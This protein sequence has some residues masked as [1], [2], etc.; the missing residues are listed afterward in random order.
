MPIY[1]GGFFLGRSDCHFVFSSA[2]IWWYSNL[3]M[4]LEPKGYRVTGLESL[5]PN[6]G[7]L[8]HI[9]AIKGEGRLIESFWDIEIAGRAVDLWT[10]VQCP[11]MMGSRCEHALLTVILAQKQNQAPLWG[12][13]LGLI[14]SRGLMLSF[15]WWTNMPHHKSEGI[16]REKK[17]RL[18]WRPGIVEASCWAF[19][20]RSCLCFWVVETFPSTEH[21]WS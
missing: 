9:L 1:S 10:R 2:S 8:Y 3:A 4:S 13:P 20:N 11:V 14:R 16:I 19:I 17:R 15:N 21:G 6:C 12:G 18:P 7:P 5:A